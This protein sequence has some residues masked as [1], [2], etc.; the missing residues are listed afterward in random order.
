M[1]LDRPLEAHEPSYAVLLR[2][3][4]ELE[5]VEYSVGAWQ[6][7]PAGALAW[8][9]SPA[10]GATN[11][12]PQAPSEA[13]LSLFDG[14]GSD[15]AQ[16]DARYVLALLMLRRRILRPDDAQVILLPDGAPDPA[17]SESLRLYSPAR[18]QSYEVVEAF[19]TAERAQ[20]IQAMLDRLLAA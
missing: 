5:R 3:G 16:A 9:L 7:P 2:A 11:R 17:P 1:A 18:D 19:P 8:W 13:L 12:K 6:G 20:E 4:A 14:L 10:P 15:P